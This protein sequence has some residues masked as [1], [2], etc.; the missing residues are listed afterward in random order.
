MVIKT[1]HLCQDEQLGEALNFLD[2][3]EVQYA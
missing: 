1:Y 2:A 3:I